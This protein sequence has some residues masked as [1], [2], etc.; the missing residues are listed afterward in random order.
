MPVNLLS[1]GGGTTTLTNAASASNFTL[2]LPASTGTIGLSGAA[3]TRSQLPAGSV[4][5]VIQTIK[6]DTFT[7]TSSSYTDITGLSVNITPTS[8]S[9]RILVIATLSYGGGTNA[10]GYA[11][12]LRNGTP[13]ALGNS[14]SSNRTENTFPMNIENTPSGD[15]KLM[16]A[17]MT[18]LDSPATTSAITYKIQA[19]S[20]NAGVTVAIN[21]SG[22]NSDNA[23][24]GLGVSS[25]TVMEIAV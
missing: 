25:I 13:I 9:N 8:A 1:S 3:V 14:D 4:L 7:T 10:Y 6:T 16:N 12:I 5:Q 23:F 17:G 2:T 18:V 24:S 19:L 21:R 11:Q 22:G 20:A 15:A